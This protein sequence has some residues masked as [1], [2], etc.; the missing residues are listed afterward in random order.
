MTCKTVARVHA[1]GRRNLIRNVNFIQAYVL[2]LSKNKNYVLQNG[3]CC[4]CSAPLPG[5][6]TGDL[7]EQTLPGFFNHE[8]L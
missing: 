7:W 2:L 5:S 3:I 8:H 4:L 1:A 6:S